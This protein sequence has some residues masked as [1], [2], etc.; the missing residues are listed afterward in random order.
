MKKILFVVLFCLS[1]F[2]LYSLPKY[3]LFEYCTGTWC[4]TCPCAHRVIADSILVQY[5]NTII[6]SYHGPLNSSDP[7]RNFNGN[8]VV[9]AMGFVSYASAV[10]NRTGAPQ[11]RNFWMPTVAGNYTDTANVE[12]IVNKNYDI[13]TRQLTANIQLRAL[14]NLTGTYYINYV[15]VEDSIIAASQNGNGQCIGGNPYR[16]DHV[17]RDMINGAQGELVTNSPW[18]YNQII[19]KSVNYNVSNVYNPYNSYL[20]V[21]VY[22][23]NG[24]SM[25][26]NTIQ[27][28]AKVRVSNNPVGIIKNSE[29]AEKYSLQQNYPNPFNPSTSIKFSIIEQDFVELNI[30]NVL[31]EKVESLVNELLNTGSYEVR[32]NA[33]NMPSGIYYYTLKTGRF[34]KT[35]KMVLIK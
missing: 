11:S 8:S 33:D 23:D 3:T 27:Q 1:S 22:K 7:Y 13:P 34:S 18:N 15:F 6:L 19:N 26:V 14:G 2:T 16:L 29:I 4:P 21:F 17:V 9:T 31:G 35:N 5:P 28:A 32:W 10:V 25:N 20:I 30:Y 12:I 24:G